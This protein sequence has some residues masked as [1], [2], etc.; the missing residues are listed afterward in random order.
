MIESAFQDVYC[1][2]PMK[3][4]RYIIHNVLKHVRVCQIF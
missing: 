1:K 3:F 4:H 2:L